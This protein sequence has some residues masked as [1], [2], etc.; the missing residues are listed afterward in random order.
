MISK[1]ATSSSEAAC[2]L[3]SFLPLHASPCEHQ[4]YADW[5]HGNEGDGDVWRDAKLSGNLGPGWVQYRK[6]LPGEC[7]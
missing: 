3:W 7:Q 4:C 2:C 5:N 1:N 6:T